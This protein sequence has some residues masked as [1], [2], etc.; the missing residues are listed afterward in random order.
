MIHMEATVQQQNPIVE[1]ANRLITIRDEKEALSEREKELNKL[2][3]ET[4]R[5]LFEL[6]ISED[7]EKFTYAGRTFRPEVKTYA[8]IRAECKEEAFAWLKENGYGDLVKEQVNA[9]SLT[10]LY[11]ELD[12]NGELPEEFAQLLN[13][14]QKQKIAV[15]RGRG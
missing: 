14:Y 9:Q 4:E 1:L 11:K 6:M 7:L 2:E 13:V 8:S 12:E 3:E 5:Q 10:S 15:R